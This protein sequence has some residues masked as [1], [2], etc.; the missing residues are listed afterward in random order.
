MMRFPDLTGLKKTFQVF[1]G[2][3]GSIGAKVVV[4]SRP[5][6]FKKNLSGLSW[7]GGQ[8]LEILGVGILYFIYINSS[9]PEN[10]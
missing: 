8:G 5:D 9:H 1:L 3:V 10:F 7:V 6:R 4:V 2:L